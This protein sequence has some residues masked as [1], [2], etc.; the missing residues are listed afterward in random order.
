M[1]LWQWLEYLLKSLTML[2]KWL[3]L[4]SFKFFIMLPII[5]QMWPLRWQAFQK[6]NLTKIVLVLNIY[7]THYVVTKYWWQACQKTTNLT[8]YNDCTGFRHLLKI[9][10]YPLTNRKSRFDII[11]TARTGSLYDKK[12]LFL[13][14]SDQYNFQILSLKLY[15]FEEFCRGPSMFLSHIC[16]SAQLCKHMVYVMS[17]FLSSTTTRA[18]T[19]GP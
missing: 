2:Q 16:Q 18:F 9:W 3:R 6:T 13:Y 15:N 5:I 19:L 1:A 8:F 11:Y 12:E 17:F 14:Q 7:S 4:G 10:L